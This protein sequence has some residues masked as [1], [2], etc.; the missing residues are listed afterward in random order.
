MRKYIL[1]I[2][3]LTAVVVSAQTKITFEDMQI[4]GGSSIYN[5]TV[6]VVSNPVTTGINTSAYCLDVVNNGYTPIR[7]SN[8]VI[9]AGLKTTYPYVKLKFKIAYK[10]YN[11]GSDLDYPQVDV[12]SSPTTPVLDAAE[13][14]GSISSA[15]G[16]HTSDSLVWKSVEFTMSSSVLTNIP[17]GILVLKVAKSKCEYLLDDIELIPSPIYNANMIT[18]TDFENNAV[19][20]VFPYNVY[21]STTSA[22]SGTCQVAVDPLLQSTKALCVTPSGYNGTINLSVILPNSK[23]LNSYD[24]LFFDLYYSSGNGLYAQPYI[25]ADNVI[26][27]QVTTGYPSQGTSSIWN[28]KDYELT[29]MTAQNSFILKIGYTSNNS[30]AYYLD[31]IKLHAKESSNQTDIHDASSATPLVAY[32]DGAC[33][34]LNMMVDKANLYDLRGRLLL[35]CTKTNDIRVDGLAAGA[36]VLK[37][38]V[39]NETYIAK[40]VR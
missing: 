2:F 4:S 8:F 30:I 13:K 3:C 39:G 15:W 12:Y 18:L 17:G 28:T 33:L 19:G 7:F 29:S 40:M 38:Q 34:R 20:D 9:P 26:I 25:A 14:L 22:A 32:S 11:G 6:S 1:F 31:N 10:G 21:W 16:M 27:Y 24:R 5:G 37:A 36:Y 23:T 35:S